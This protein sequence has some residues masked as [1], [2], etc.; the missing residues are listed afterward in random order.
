MWSDLNRRIASGVVLALVAGAL[1]LAGGCWLSV[2]VSV[3]TGGMIWELTRLTGLRHSRPP[4]CCYPLLVGLLGGLTLLVMVSVPGHGAV[5]LVLVPLVLTTGRA[6]PAERAGHAL[7]M[8]AIL[9]AGY[10]LVTIRETAGL[11]TLLWIVATV[12]LSDVLGYFAGRRLGGPRFWPAISPKK[13]WSGT[14]A[15]WIGAFVLALVVAACGQAGWSILIVAPLL[16]LAG[17][18]GDIGESWLKRRVGVKDASDLIPGHGG[19][20]DRFDAMSGSILTAL[21]LLM[22]GILPVIGG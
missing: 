2:G 15:G 6:A 12:A 1:I 10:G 8:L 21:L 13:T 9:L 4:A 17:Q 19:L 14:I 7:F 18:M 20:M 16:A 22:M 11:G 5:V 3:L